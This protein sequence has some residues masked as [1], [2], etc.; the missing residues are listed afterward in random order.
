MSQFTTGWHL[1]LS[2]NVT[3]TMS[4]VEQSFGKAYSSYRKVQDQ[5]DNSTRHVKTYG[6]SIDDLNRKLDNLTKARNISVNV[7][8][9]KNLNREIENTLSQ[10]NRMSSRGGQWGKFKEGLSNIPG[11]GGLMSLGTNPYALGA[12]GIAGA[13][14]FGLESARTRFDYNRKFAQ[15]NATA[16]LDPTGLSALRNEIMEMGRGSSTPLEQVPLAYEKI[17]SATGKVKQST[18]IL[19]YSLQGAQAGFA[20]VNEVASATVGIVN[21][22]G[23]GKTNAKTVMDV[24]FASKRLGVGEFADFSRYLPGNITQGSGLGYDYRD[25]AGSFSYLTTK[26]NRADVT[27]TLLSNLFTSLGR[28]EVTDKLTK[29]GVGVYGADGNRRDLFSVFSDLANKLEGRSQ[30]GRDALLGDIFTDAQAKQAVNALLNDVDGLG[31]MMRET[32]NSAGELDKALASTANEMN[33]VQQLNNNWEFFKDNMGKLFA[34]MLNTL[35][36]GAN[37]VLGRANE[38][39][40]VGNMTYDQQKEYW[41]KKALGEMRSGGDYSSTLTDLGRTMS[42]N[43][44][45]SDNISGYFNSLKSYS[46]ITNDD[47]RKDP[48]KWGLKYY[49]KLGTPRDFQGNESSTINP[50]TGATKGGSGL[51]TDSTLSNIQG[52]ISGGGN[53]KN[54]TVTISQLKTADQLHIHSAST[55]EGMKDVE[56]KLFESLIRVVNSVEASAGGAN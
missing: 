56:D 5:L 42:E 15:I 28:S 40:S 45:G 11:V 44:L 49:G 55:D 54:F 21:A 2:D 14:A 48:R 34:P 22:V 37:N 3:Q 26:G 46:Q 1:R 6:S 13:G 50:T 43:G 41:T 23:E 4:K 36:G 24:L 19:R 16:Q 12:A 9:I 53:V 51:A 8:D 35:I 39:S 32:R 25:V 18:D 7:G 17:L 52:N 29:Q 10:I 30:K 33:G 27:S 47:I 31:K 20:D 38:R